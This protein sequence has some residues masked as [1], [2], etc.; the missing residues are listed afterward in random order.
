MISP[1]PTLYILLTTRRLRSLM[2]DF[3]R[4]EEGDHD[5]PPPLPAIVLKTHSVEMGQQLQLRI[6]ADQKLQRF[7]KVPNNYPV[8]ND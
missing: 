7:N 3:A 8:P 5:R 4:A 6:A 1:L 2:H